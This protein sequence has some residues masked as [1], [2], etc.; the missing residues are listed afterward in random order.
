MRYVQNESEILCLNHGWRFIEKDFSV[1]PPEAS[2]KHDA[3]YRYAKAGAQL[4]PASADFDDGDWSE[5]SLPHDWVPFKDFTPD[6]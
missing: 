2:I 6:A 3:I 5:V 4:G 1:L